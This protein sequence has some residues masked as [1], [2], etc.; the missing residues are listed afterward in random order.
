M[1]LVAGLALV[2]R[3]GQNLLFHPPFAEDYSDMAG[4][5]GRARDMFDKPWGPTPSVTFFPYGTHFFVYGVERVFGRLN[6]T[7][8]GIAFALIG[9]LAVVFS[10]LAAKLVFPGRPRPAL[11]VGLVLALYPPWIK[12]GGFVLSEMPV[13][14]A[15]AAACYF[16]L[17]FLGERRLRDAAWLGASI[18]LG[19]TFRPQLLAAL[20]FLLPF[21]F[22]VR[23]RT[24]G[25]ATAVGVLLLP[26]AV[27]LA[28]SAWRMNYHTGHYGFIAT[29]GP[30]NLVFGRCHC[31]ELKARKTWG[32]DFTPPSFNA[33]EHYE[34]EFGVRPLLTLDPAFGR[35]LMINGRLWESEPALDLARK[36]VCETGMARQAKYSLTHL[37]L[38]WLY[39]GPWPSSSGAVTILSA[40]FHCVA[41]APA[42]FLGWVIALRRRFA[43]VLALTPHLLG[44]FLT[45]VVFFGEAR[46]RLPYDGIIATMAVYAYDLA[47]P[48][49]RAWRARRRARKQPVTLAPEVPGAGTEEAPPPAPLA[50]S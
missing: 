23:P 21:L 25:R 16:T 20:P 22:F 32:S 28:G 1:L 11:L 3:L 33:L 27:M 44:M 4:Y 31:T 49:L 18:A 2:L 13:A 35:K 34:K 6:G 17:R 36:C 5:L 40:V 38:L 8:I 50:P 19:A 47:W 29:N 15:L 46:L 41:M 48:W 26:V 37:M 7:A 24:K 30:F 14:V 9:T 10:H 45:A 42:M 12:Q 43:P 39:N